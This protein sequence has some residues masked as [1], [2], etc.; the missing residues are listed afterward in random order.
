M[1]GDWSAGIYAYT[2]SILRT[3]TW[4]TRS[5]LASPTHTTLTLSPDGQNA[6]M[7]YRAAVPRRSRMYPKTALLSS[8]VQLA[9][10][11]RF[12]LPC[13]VHATLARI[14]L[15]SFAAANTAF[16][17]VPTSLVVHTLVGRRH[18]TYYGGVLR[19]EEE[20]ASAG[21]GL[22]STLKT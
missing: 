19:T 13:Y 3:C 8:L 22:K 14:H 15:H 17:A 9:N 21:W 12:R 5:S 18:Q 2:Y 11:L 10:R 1:V 7:A 16:N 20:E 4:G 6:R